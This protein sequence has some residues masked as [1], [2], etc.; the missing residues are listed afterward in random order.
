LAILESQAP[1]IGTWGVLA[2]LIR[3]VSRL[4]DRAEV[5]DAVPSLVTRI[6]FDR[7]FVSEVVDGAWMPAAV[8]VPRDRR[9]AD[10]IR[11]AGRNA[12]QRLGAGVVEDQML[13]SARPIHV[14][15]VRGNPR[16]HQGIAQVSRSQAYLAAPVGVGDRLGAIVHV[17]R[18]WSRR[19]FCSEDVAALQ[20]AGEVIGLVLERAALRESLERGAVPAAGTEQAD[21]G[22]ER[23]GPERARPESASSVLSALTPREHEVAAMIADGLT[24]AQIAAELVVAE[25]TV[26]THI[27]HI[28]RKLG[29]RHRAE[30]VAMFLRSTPVGG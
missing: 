22:P 29:A 30:A 19:R 23:T 26:K 24:N 5:L 4:N 11:E 20:A 6:G 10:D 2:D 12:P 8:Y 18:F 15:R 3:A 7:A 14:D 25:A 1:V 21:G 13:S 17:D 27:K 28:L 9:W 16:V